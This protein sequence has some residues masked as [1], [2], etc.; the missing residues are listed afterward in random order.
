MS[1]SAQVLPML[2]S[3]LIS[4]VI[5]VWMAKES[6]HEGVLNDIVEKAT[7]H[8]IFDSSLVIFVFPALAHNVGAGIAVWL[9]NTSF[10]SHDLNPCPLSIGTLCLAKSVVEAKLGSSASAQ[11][12][13]ERLEKF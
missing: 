11:P 12:S 6:L 5:G 8:S 10:G 7:F 4:L 9:S 2:F 3:P 13:L 1:L